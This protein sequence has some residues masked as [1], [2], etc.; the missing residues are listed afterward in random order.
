MRSSGSSATS[1]HTTQPTPSGASPNLWPDVLIDFTR[2]TRKSHS[3]SGAQNGARNPP[4]AA[5]TWMSMS[6]P[7]S[8]CSCVERVGQRL[9]QLVAARVGDAERR[10]H[11]DRVLVDTGQHVVG[12]HAVV[13]RRHRH[14]AHLDVPV[15]GELV[16]HHLHRPAHHVRLV[17]GL[18]LRFTLGPPSPLG[19][20]AGQH[21]GLGRADA[22]RADGVGRLGCVPEVGHHVHAAALDLGG[23]RVL[24]LVDHVLVDA[25]VHERVH[26]GLLPRLAEG[27][28]VL[29]GVA[30]EH[31]LVVHGL[32]RRRQGGSRPWGTGTSAWPW[33]GPGRRR[34]SPRGARGS[35]CG[36][37]ASWRL[38]QWRRRRGDKRVDHDPGTCARLASSPQA[39]DDAGRSAT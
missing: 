7:V 6:R 8:A 36:R 27:G 34:S 35:S 28:Q 13:P 30:V 19:R 11:E 29:A 23:L 26:L 22:R 12:V 18:A 9:H 20:H 16:P 33:T 10:H 25:Q 37:A 3:R 31:E 14:L 32:V 4:L 24:V 38:F 17:G 39:G 1:R 5:S 21:A 2:G 15:L